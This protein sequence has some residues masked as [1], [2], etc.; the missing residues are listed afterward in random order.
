MKNRLLII[1]LAIC[2]LFT[3][4]TSYARGGGY[5][6]DAY[7]GGIPLS[8][9]LYEPDEIAEEARV[10]FEY[11]P[12]EQEALPD[13][14]E[15]GCKAAY[16][17]DP[18]SGKVF[19]EKN[20]HEKMY[21]ASTTKILTALLVLENCDPDDIVTVS[22]HAIDLKPEG[23][24]S[25]NLRA[26]EKLSI[27]TLLQ[28]LLIPSAN[29]AAY[30]LAE[31]VSGSVDAFASL[32]NK[33]AKELGCENLHFVNPNGV[34]DENHYC[35]AY[36]LYLIARECKKYDVFNEI[37]STREFTVPAT[38]VYPGSDRKYSNTNE[39][40]LPLSGNYYSYCTGIKTGHTTPAG[41]CLVSSSSKDNLDLICVVMGGRII[42]STNERFSDTKKLL[43]FVYD[44]YSY[45][46]IADKSKPLAQINIDNAVKDTPM[47]DVV[48]QT[49]I[50]TVAPNNTTGDNV[51]TQV[52][53]PDELKA[54]IQKN[55]VLG[56]VTYRVD[57]LVYTTNMVAGN[58]VVKKP[59][60]L[61][62]SLVSLAAALI[63]I[64]IIASVKKSKMRKT[65]STKRAY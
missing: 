63:V 31:H 59:F 46:M 32:C 34:H 47:L 35:S 53:L 36:D 45:K 11:I 50:V 8:G 7:A 1:T 57:G 49:D 44:N 40:L 17:A 38:D 25:A 29:E 10:T 43:D 12:N 20:A 15:I 2:L 58:E 19:Y 23:Y 24:S 60:W 51:I 13:A 3:P 41:E 4:L 21:P 28:A 14:P 22:Q 65:V 18:V 5:N 55:Q 9:S 6:P 42:G 56:T 54:P 62:N 16:L 27:Y 39:L 37:V 61:Y 33:R 52:S 48:L 30:A 26:G 64:I